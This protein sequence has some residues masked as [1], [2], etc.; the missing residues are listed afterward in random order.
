M[1]RLC[2]C[3]SRCC[4]CC[5][6]CDVWPAPLFPIWYFFK[7]WH[8]HHKPNM[9]FQYT[10]AGFL[11]LLVSDCRCFWSLSRW[12]RKRVSGSLCS[13]VIAWFLLYLVDSET[14][15]LPVCV[16]PVCL[17]R[18]LMTPQGS[19]MGTITT[20]TIR[21]YLLLGHPWFSFCHVVDLPFAPG[22]TWFSRSLVSVCLQ[23]WRF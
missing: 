2:S 13:S 3:C 8:F 7:Y 21:E 17:V 5:C 18:F 11:T 9:S 22:S 16:G 19:T 1:N 4:C 14:N 10:H 12:F 15:Y 23:F 20:F 6:C